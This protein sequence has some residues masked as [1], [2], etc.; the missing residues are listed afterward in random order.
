MAS[1]GGLSGG[2]SSSSIYGTRNVLSGLASGEMSRISPPF[3]RLI[4]LPSLIGG[5]ISKNSPPFNYFIMLSCLGGGEVHH[6][7]VLNPA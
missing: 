2:S 3:S 6:R 4:V 1:I 5:E 7:K